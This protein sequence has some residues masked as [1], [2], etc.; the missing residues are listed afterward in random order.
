MREPTTTSKLQPR[1]HAGIWL[2]QADGSDE[3]KW[4]VGLGRRRSES[5][6]G[7]QTTRGTR[8]KSWTSSRACRGGSRVESP[9]CVFDILV[10]GVL[11]LFLWLLEFVAGGVGTSHSREVVRHW[12]ALHQPRVRFNGCPLVEQL[13]HGRLTR[14]PVTPGRGRPT[15]GQSAIPGRGPL[16]DQPLHRRSTGGPATPGVHW[17]TPPQGEA[18]SWPQH[19]RRCPPVDQQH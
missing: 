2:N 17:W 18:R 14:G 3:H 1:W 11:E 4:R 5:F 6:D 9:P 7:G 12:R 16:V 15:G 13:L 10:G 19:S 8:P